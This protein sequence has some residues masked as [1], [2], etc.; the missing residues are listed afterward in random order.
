MGEIILECIRELCK[1]SLPELE[2]FNE[3]WQQELDR[4]GAKPGV[5]K[6]CALMVNAIIEQKNSK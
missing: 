1:L 5:K 3:E 4:I 2:E 6:L